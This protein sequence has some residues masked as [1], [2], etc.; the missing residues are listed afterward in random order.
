[1]TRRLIVEEFVFR[2][3][4]FPDRQ[5]LVL[6]SGE[7]CTY[8]QLH[9]LATDI[10]S[11]VLSHSVSSG[12][13]E[14]TALVCLMMHRHA[15]LVASMLGVLMAGAAY[16]PVDPAFPPDR[17]TYI[18]EHSRCQ[19]LIVDE[20][21]HRQ[22]LSLGV[23][24]PPAIVISAEGRVI[25]SPR[26][27]ALDESGEALGRA[28][29]SCHSR[30]MGGLMYVLYTSGSTG[31]PKGVMVQQY[32][33]TN[34]VSWFA[35]EIG[36]NERSRVL[37]LT[38]ACFDISVLEIYM[39]LTR[40]GTLVLA[41][42][43]S[44]KDPFRLLE[45]MR[46]ESVGVFQAT[47]TTY[48]MM[49]ATGWRGDRSI[50]FLVGGEA[51]RP[52]LIQLARESR[53]LRNVYGPTETTIWSSSFTITE[54]YLEKQSLRSAPV[55]PVGRPISETTFH[56]IDVETAER[57]EFREVDGFVEAEGE[58]W[59]GGIGVARGY[60]HR[61]DLTESRFLANPFGEG[62]VYRTGDLVRRLE[63][64]DYLFVRRLDDQVK[65]DGFRIELA[66]IEN[67]YGQYPLVEQAVVIVRLG[68]LS[69]YLKIRDNQTHSLKQLQDIKDFVS[70]SLTYYM[71]PTFTT[72]VQS[73]PKT[74]NGK[75]D[76]NALPDPVLPIVAERVKEEE[77]DFS[78]DRTMEAHIRGIVRD[79]RGIT[80]KSNSTF[81]AIGVDSLGAVLL[82][83]ALSDSLGGVRIKP[84]QIFRPGVTVRSFADELY[85]QLLEEQPDVLKKLG[86]LPNSDVEAVD[87]KLDEYNGVDETYEAA[88]SEQIASNLRL[89]Q[90]IRGAY[91]ALGTAFFDI[92]M[93]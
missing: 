46:R 41:D 8:G 34:V 90:G 32:G 86:I 55:I 16:V 2:V 12:S 1:M 54:Q 76:R 93:S 64:G 48:E 82:I 11:C 81:A 59:I 52:S 91:M 70:R 17:Q 87:G 71:V 27:Y 49:L 22:A 24:V 80:V 15:G 88:F 60:L 26:E 56:L 58:L 5:A 7:S 43:A 6:E 92:T 78:E 3:H 25:A 33:V 47:P 79:Q 10:G 75:L 28:R 4:Q 42:S 84:G 65:V 18:F 77:V 67:V 51:F 31:K 73:F 62:A 68:K 13:G 66:E 69:A 40:G 21:C 89:I 44:Q 23:A 29:L 74:A 53:S 45:L 38:T 36:V 20:D 35:D 72:I 85:A 50:D 19:M 39:P 63:T 57:G 37:G 83:R 14:D 61:A 9:S 30:R